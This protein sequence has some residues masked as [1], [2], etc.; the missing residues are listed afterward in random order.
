MNGQ[1]LPEF[2]A[3][4][5]LSWSPTEALEK[6]GQLASA[7]G[8]A[9]REGLIH[10][11]ICPEQIL[12]EASG[13]LQLIGLELPDFLHAAPARLHYRSPEQLN[14]LSSAVDGRTDIYGLGAVLYEVLT[15]NPPHTPTPESTLSRRI[16]KGHIVEPSQIRP[17]IGSTANSICLTALS[18]NPTTRYEMPIDLARD[19]ERALQGHATQASQ[20][21]QSRNKAPGWLLLTSALLLLL[22][23]GLSLF[24]LQ[25]W[26][27]HAPNSARLSAEAQCRLLQNL[28]ERKVKE[29]EYQASAGRWQ[30]VLELSDLFLI[31]FSQSRRVQALKRSASDQGA[32]DPE[33]IARSADLLFPSETLLGKAAHLRAQAIEQKG[34]LPLLPPAYLS[35]FRYAFGSPLA[36]QSLA[37]LCHAFSRTQQPQ[38]TLRTALWFSRWYPDHKELAAVSQ[39]GAQAAEALGEPRLAEKLYQMASTQRI[40]DS[41]R[42][43][44]LM[45]SLSRKR[46]L[47]LDAS[48]MSLASLNR[49]PGKE[50]VIWD[51]SK[52]KLSVYTF[53]GGPLRFLASYSLPDLRQA[54]LITA[55]INGYG[56]PEIILVGTIR[57]EWTTLFF[58]WRSTADRPI[59]AIGKLPLSGKPNPSGLSVGDCDNDGKQDLIVTHRW[60]VQIYSFR[61]QTLDS[62]PLDSKTLTLL[63]PRQSFIGDIDGNGS[64]DIIVSLSSSKKLRLYRWDVEQ[65]QH[66]YFA[67]ISVPG[68]QTFRVLS[69]QLFPSGGILTYQRSPDNRSGQ[70]PGSLTLY[71]S[72]SPGKVPV[73]VATL[74]TTDIGLNMT[75]HL[76]RWNVPRSGRGIRGYPA[77]IHLE[78]SRPNSDESQRLILLRIRRIADGTKSLLREAYQ[79]TEPTGHDR[80]LMVGDIDGDG[81][82]DLLF[83]GLRNGQ[84][85]ISIYGARQHLDSS[86]KSSFQ[87]HQSTTSHSRLSLARFLLA[88]EEHDSAREEFTIAHS[89]APLASE[90]GNALSYQNPKEL[91]QAIEKIYSFLQQSPSS[92]VEAWQHI[93]TMSQ[94]NWDFDTCAQILRTMISTGD[95]EGVESRLAHRRLNRLQPIIEMQRTPRTISLDRNVPLQASHPLLA[96]YREGVFQL[97]DPPRTSLSIPVRYT[98]APFGLKV[99]GRGSN[100][101]S[102]GLWT[103]KGV[104]HLWMEIDR[105]E[106]K[107]HIHFSHAPGEKRHWTFQSPEE[108]A[109]DSPW[110]YHLWVLP[111]LREARLEWIDPATTKVIRFRRIFLGPTVPVISGDYLFGILPTRIS[112]DSNQTPNNPVSIE[113]LQIV[114]T[115]MG[116]SLRPDQ[117]SEPQAQKIFGLLSQNQKRSVRK[118]LNRWNPTQE[119]AQYL[120]A[121]TQLTCGLTKP[122]MKTLTELSQTHPRSTLHRWTED[123][124]LLSS[125]TRSLIDKILER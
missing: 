30:R 123:R 82:E 19:I 94:E 28:A 92:R 86:Q 46:L 37:Q 104:P 101:I 49:T 57:S 16:R 119:S 14:P 58:S 24:T 39:A 90:L 115:G 73:P 26:P 38:K 69:R 95:L 34:R 108:K 53:S 18:P 70:E 103:P 56:S 93:L 91:E 51:Q 22:A 50:L 31:S 106:A 77:L 11:G 88:I 4:K 89:E 15:G 41:S 10:G 21:T 100:L 63:E 98:E 42:K 5:T 2:I 112:V 9:H 97:A 54:Q 61:S 65:N 3:T 20:S 113:T 13:T 83:S 76:N 29:I 75:T 109:P 17:E 107:V 25:S 62:T 96:T 99:S 120:K 35:A 6:I 84:Q 74:P 66:I 102:V 79:L 122:A 23:L 48:H 40:A 114:S 85:T 64:Q 124:G 1:P 68:L 71:Q 117:D 47:A 116:I 45:G 7:L 52:Q 111:S 43:A 27:T 59:R 121:L 110:L 81:C 36:P 60:G 78:P 125:E 67:E 105:F 118:L 44:A 32:H 33:Q 12:V 72:P 80:Q 55:D 8:S 87:E